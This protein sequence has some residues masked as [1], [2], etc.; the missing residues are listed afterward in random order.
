MAGMKDDD[1]L[2]VESGEWIFFLDFDVASLSFLSRRYAMEKVL[3]CM[4]RW[5]TVR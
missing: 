5:M 4:D 1:N 3:P 2:L